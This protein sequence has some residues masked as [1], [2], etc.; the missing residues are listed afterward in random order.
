MLTN[1][2]VLMLGRSDERARLGT[3]P[4]SCT[5]ALR[6]GALTSVRAVARSA[7]RSPLCFA[8]AR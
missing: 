1:L 7:S 5:T 6:S 8:C 2:V 4:P 3:A